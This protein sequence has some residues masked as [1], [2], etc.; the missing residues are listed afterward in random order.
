[1]S[2]RLFASIY[3]TFPPPITAT[4]LTCS[5]SWK[6]VPAK[7]SKEWDVPIKISLSFS[8]ISVKP[9]GI[10][11]KSSL[12]IPTIIVSR[13]KPQS[14]TILPTIEDPGR[15]LYSKSLALP[16]AKFST[17]SACATVT[18]LNNSWVK[19]ASGQIT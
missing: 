16:S 1:M 6:N 9:F 8:L 15:T 2:S 3:P 18:I 5:F 10:N 4:D 17:S 13:V 12:F 14:F 19:R 7:I 11:N